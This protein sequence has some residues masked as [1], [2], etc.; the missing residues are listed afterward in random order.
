[1]NIVQK[2][3]S[4]FWD[5]EA[6]ELSVPFFFVSMYTYIY[7]IGNIFGNTLLNWIL[8]WHRGR[9]IDVLDSRN[10]VIPGF[11]YGYT[12][13]RCKRNSPR[14]RREVGSSTLEPLRQTVLLNKSLISLNALIKAFTCSPDHGHT[15]NH[16][17]D[18]WLS[19]KLMKRKLWLSPYEQS[20]QIREIFLYKA[21]WAHEGLINLIAPSMV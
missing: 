9:V 13:M 17:W 7:F 20:F 21:T 3:P 19:D 1:M 6:E 2:P 4:F 8:F 14:A 12:F 5:L 10:K 16:I 18:Q 15:L 11:G